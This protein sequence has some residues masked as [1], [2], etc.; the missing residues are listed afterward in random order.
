[1]VRSRPLE[2]GYQSRIRTS[3]TRLAF[4]NGAWVAA[5]ALMAFGPKFLWNQVL[6]FTLLA[7][8]LDVIVGVGMILA[9]IRYVMGLDELQQKVYLNALGITVGVGLIAGV[10][11]S[12]MGSYHV[13][14][15]RADIGHLLLLMGLTFVVSFLY[16]TRRYR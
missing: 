9:T 15:F 5:T 4:W 11:Y 16:G 12:V 10:P 13:I 14:P 3:L 6:A 8:S 7:I 1:M 2:R